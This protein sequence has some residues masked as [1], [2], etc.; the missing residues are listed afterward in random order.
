VDWASL[1]ATVVDGG[2]VGGAAV[3]GAFVSVI[4]AVVVSGT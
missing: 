1:R 4:A 2:V 3:G